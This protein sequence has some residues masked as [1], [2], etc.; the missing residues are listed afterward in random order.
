VKAVLLNQLPY[1]QPERLV[2]V[3]ES[4]PDTPRPACHPGRPNGGAAI[5][6][7]SRWKALGDSSRLHVF[8]VDWGQALPRR[9]ED[10]R[11]RQVFG[12]GSAALC[13]SVVAVR[14][15]S[16]VDRT[17]LETRTD[18]WSGWSSRMQV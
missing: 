12:C 7:K 14:V 11:N 3:A 4:D 18:R 17:F 6:M 13:S 2:T 9:R 8:V 1:R 16:A 15:F 10:A 5:R